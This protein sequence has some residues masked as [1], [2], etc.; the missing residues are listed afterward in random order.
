M[1]EMIIILLFV[2]ILSGLGRWAT[3]QRFDRLYK[4]KMEKMDGCCGGGCC[5]HENRGK[6]S[7][8]ANI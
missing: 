4:E 7:E 3:K 2:A 8:N 6:G 1:I 5:N